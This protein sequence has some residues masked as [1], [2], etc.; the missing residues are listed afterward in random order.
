MSKKDIE[1]HDEVRNAQEI[2]RF[3]QVLH[4]DSFRIIQG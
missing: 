1:K 4:M 2:F 3:S